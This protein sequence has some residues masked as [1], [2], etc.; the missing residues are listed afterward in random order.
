[1]DWN[2]PDWSM[3]GM[4]G[5]G[6]GAHYLLH[7]AVDH[8]DLE[9]AEWM[10]SHGANANVPVCSHPKFRPAQSLYET[11]VRSGHDEMAALLER[12]GAIKRTVSLTGAEEF[13]NAAFRLNRTE[14]ARLS[15]EH[16]E[17]LQSTAAIFEASRRDRADV[18][19]L[20]LDLGVSPN[21]ADETGQRPLHVAAHENSLNAARV[22][23]ER[24]A[25]IDPVDG[26]WG[27]TPLGAANYAQHGEMI[28]YLTPLS[29]DFWEIVY[30]GS[31]DRA[32]SLL[33]SSPERARMV[34]DNG[35]TP[36][37]WLPPSNE[38]RA[39][40]MAKLLVLHGADRTIRNS[41]GQTAA[42]RADR[43]GMHAAAEYL[44]LGAEPESS[45]P[46]SAPI[47]NVE[48]PP[49]R[50]GDYELRAQALL[51]AYRTGTPDAMRRHWAF[52]WHHRGWAAMRTYVQ[53]DLGRAAD[54]PDKDRDI[55]I[56]DARLLIAREHGFD[57]WSSLDAY[58]A[59][60]FGA[61]SAIAMKPL[62]LL[63][64]GERGRLR[65]VDQ[66]RDWDSLIAR[67]DDEH[68]DG[69]DAR[70]QMTDALLEHVTRLDHIRALKLSGSSGVT[71][72]GMRLLA[73][74]PRLE[75]LELDG[76]PITDE[77]MKVV[78]ALREL[79]S[80]SLAWTG[81]TDAGA[82]HVAACERLEN[83]N[84]GGTQ[85]GDGAIAALRGKP[86]LRYLTTGNAVSD[87]GLP[88]L[89]DYP[90]FKKWR[91]SASFSL[92]HHDT[93]P[94]RLVAR[95]R[96]TDRGLAA[97][98][99]LDGLFALD[100]GDRDLAIT[101]AGLAPLTDMANLGSLAFDAHDDAM[102]YIAALP[103]LRFLSCQDT[104]AT[105]DG[106]AALGESRSIERIWGRRCYGLR[107]RGFASLSNMPALRALA[108]SCK[109]V[110][111]AA[112]ALLPSF[113]ALRELM[114]MDVPDEGYRHIG[115]C[116]ELDA[117]ILMYCRDTTDRSTEHI[118]G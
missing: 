7:V 2:D 1:A 33:E 51:D 108:A 22:L 29:G 94:S 42:D 102:P 118:A 14:T 89:H 70:G 57:S 91:N 103:R 85:T 49:L 78:G 6:P 4:G 74:L 15:A 83:V 28:A 90:A 56:D 37:M 97:L 3:L 31:L 96:L 62:I 5:Y 69:I 111:D 39:L 113:P 115:R 99:G 8:N 43:M 55:A 41:D 35:H 48:S 9:A 109:N 13:S 93:P 110:S 92:F 23:V 25:D 81:V 76:C 30:A 65:A 20:L 117:L 10:L 84:L 61:P 86:E 72:D 59:G 40:D 67:L 54:D 95:G 47:G 87:A 77:G 64:L 24:G 60:L 100:V 82:A 101:G 98:A 21:I 34:T 17:Y 44:R 46:R 16:P 58:V 36:L 112:L 116:A 66:T 26:K 18:V 19:G 73:R 38:Q 104:D 68:L 11:A 63:R 27:N 79:R 45:G 12:Y 114:P 32:R 107:D 106:W 53:L 105:D 75:H 88:V 52:T 50:L 80:L 71:D